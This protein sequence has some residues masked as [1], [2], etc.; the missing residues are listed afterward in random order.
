MTRFSYIRNSFGKPRITIA[1]KLDVENGKIYYGYSICSYRDQFRKNIGRLIAE[2][3]ML[4]Y[5]QL[6]DDQD[7]VMEGF[8]A[9]II[10]AQNLNTIKAHEVTKLV[11]DRIKEETKYQQKIQNLLENW[12]YMYNTSQEYYRDLE[13]EYKEVNRF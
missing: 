4:K 12:Y 13:P 2:G 3:R 5:S 8:S 6:Y 11:V 7:E 10:Y 9:G 1:T